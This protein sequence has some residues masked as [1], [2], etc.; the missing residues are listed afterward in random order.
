M[1][2]ACGT[3]TVV[4]EKENDIMKITKV[5]VSALSMVAL[6]CGAAAANT[7]VNISGAAFQPSNVS[8]SCAS[9]DINTVRNTCSSGQNFYASLPLLPVGTSNA[10]FWVDGYNP[11]GQTTTCY[12]Y[13]YNYDYTLLGLA[14]GATSA[15]G[16]FDLGIALPPAALSSWAY[17]TIIC[18]VPSGGTLL[19]V[20]QSY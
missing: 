15:T 13:S 10:T 12:I 4:T 2:R 14:N 6:W 1:L 11:A 3:Q 5:I 19:G 9:Y 18:N 8:T 16:N 17:L 20:A 7:N